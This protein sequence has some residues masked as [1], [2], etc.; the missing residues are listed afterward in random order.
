MPENQASLALVDLARGQSPDAIATQLETALTL[1]GFF[2]LAGHGI[3]PTVR[4]T[5]IGQMHQFFEGPESRRKAIAINQHNRGYLARG[6]ARMYGAARADLKEVFFFGRELADDDPDLLAGVPLCAP[7]QWP[8][9]QP[10]FRPAVL[11]YLS[12]VGLAA[13]QLLQGFALLLGC[14]VDFFEAYYQRPLSRGQLIHY[15]AP[16]ADAAP[17][18]FGVAEHTD[19]GSI[20]LLYQHTPGL[21]VLGRDGEWIAAPPIDGTLVVNIG[22]LLERWTA[23]ALPSTR[24]RVRNQTGQGRYSVAIFFD[25]S[26]TATIDPRDIATAR[27][28]AGLAPQW[29]DSQRVREFE[30]VGAAEYII[31]RSKGV[32]AQFQKTAA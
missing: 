5:L 11:A 9:E 8:L 15:P 21:E 28:A 16:P 7:N 24:H 26:P 3:A 2:Y 27:Q 6:E 31:G 12:Q 23:G 13:R 25:P 1:A 32:F 17:D 30:P 14:P 10:G 22:D 20:T 18:Q 29:R 4:D 19:F